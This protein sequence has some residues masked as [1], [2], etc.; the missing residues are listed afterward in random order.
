LI[1][2]S[3]FAAVSKILALITIPPDSFFIIRIFLNSANQFCRPKNSV[4]VYGKIFVP[5]FAPLT[6]LRV[7]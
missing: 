7:S 2:K 4:V 6:Q 1:R 3:G 5:V